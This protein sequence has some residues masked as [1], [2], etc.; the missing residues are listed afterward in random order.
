MRWITNLDFWSFLRWQP[1]LQR[2]AVKRNRENRRHFSL[3]EMRLIRKR[4][5]V[6]VSSVIGIY[7][8]FTLQIK[9]VKREHRSIADI[10]P[11]WKWIVNHVSLSSL[12]CQRRHF[13]FIFLLE[14][15]SLLHVVLV[16]AVQQIN[17]LSRL[18]IRFPSHFRCQKKHWIETL[19]LPQLGFSLNFYLYNSAYETIHDYRSNDKEI[20][21]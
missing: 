13:Y 10:F 11:P 1:A 4:R 15:I 12:S 5:Q 21:R 18:Y 16:S 2:E 3:E 17:Q 7:L 20:Q 14:Q 19:K 8:T 9:T 6:R